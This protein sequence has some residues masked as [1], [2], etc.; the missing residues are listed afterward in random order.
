MRTR[1]YEAK[2]KFWGRLCFQESSR[3]AKATI[4]S[5][6]EEKWQSNWLKEIISIRKEVGIPT[7]HGV[8]SYKQWC[9][10]V[11]KS[12]TDWEDKL[13]SKAKS[14][15]KSL[16]W[17]NTPFNSKRR[18]LPYINGSDEAKTFFKLKSGCWVLKWNGLCHQKCKFCG[19][20]DNELH[21]IFHCASLKNTR[22][23]IGLTTLLTEIGRDCNSEIEIIGSLTSGSKE[24]CLERGKILLKLHNAVEP[25]EVSKWMGAI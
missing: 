9:N 8:N 10:L 16:M 17:Y 24:K 13:F 7:M 11:S 4:K 21:R 2:L 20:N 22:D 6:I 3:W 14:T 15:M 23:Q 12:L 5:S 1:I 19:E 18:I 25:E